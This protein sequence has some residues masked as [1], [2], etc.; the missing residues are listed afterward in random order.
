MS[1]E[2]KIIREKRAPNEEKKERQYLFRLQSADG[3]ETSF[4]SPIVQARVIRPLKN[5]P[6][7]R[8]YK[9]SKYL[10]VERSEDGEI[11]TILFEEEL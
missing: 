2:L 9:L 5:F 10:Q 6:G 4:L 7:E 3:L 11:E 1:K 8:K